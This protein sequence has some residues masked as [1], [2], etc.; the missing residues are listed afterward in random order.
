MIILMQPSLTL[1]RCNETQEILNYAK[2][3]M[4]LDMANDTE[5]FML[6]GCLS[7][8]DKYSY[9]VQS[10]GDLQV[11]DCK[12]PTRNRVEISF[13]LP[14]GLHEIREQAR[15]HKIDSGTGSMKSIN[16]FTVHHL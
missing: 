6:T 16:H 9:I 14:S 4:R 7:K 12:D 3:S 2:Y 10:R 13:G 5:I 11:T 8:C 1:L 15:I